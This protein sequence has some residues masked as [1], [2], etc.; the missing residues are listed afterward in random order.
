MGEIWKAQDEKLG[1][2]VAV[3][4]PKSGLIASDDYRRRLV[5]EARL[6]ASINS[7]YIASVYDADE[8]DGTLFLVMEMVDGRSM[9]E[10]ISQGPQSITL[11]LAWA[12]EM[13]EGLAVAHGA[14]LVHRDLKPEN[15]MVTANDHVK[16]LDFGLAKLLEQRDKAASE[17]LS[18]AE[19]ATLE[20][21]LP[22]TIWGTPAYMSPEQ[23]RGLP[24]DARSDVFS[25]GVLLYELTTR[26]SPFKA[27]TAL[28]S[29]TA[30]L[31]S[32]PP[33]PSTLR[34]ELPQE[35]E[36][37]ILRCLQK[38]PSHRYNDTRDLLA[39]LQGV[40]PEESA[41]VASSGSRRKHQ[42]L[43]RIVPALLLLIGMSLGLSEPIRKAVSERLFPGETKP[44]LAV[45]F[46]ENLGPSREDDYLAAGLTEDIITSLSQIQNLGVLSR[47]AVE[48]YRD[49]HVDPRDV[50]RDLGANYVLEGSIRKRGDELIVTAQLIEA[51]QGKHVWARRFE[52]PFAEI[53]AVQDSI[54]FNVAHALQIPVGT[55]EQKLVS[56]RWTRNTEAYAFFLAGRERYFNFKTPTR[57]SDARP[58]FEKALA[59]DPEYAPALAG[60]SQ[61]LSAE[62]RL[63]GVLRPGGIDRALELA[64]QA[65]TLDPRLGFAWRAEGLA[66][67]N[68]NREQEA[69]TA[70]E[71][72]I[73]LGPR[74]PENYQ[75][76]NEVLRA[77]GQWAQAE[78]VAWKG[79]GM[80][81][82][83]PVAYRALASTQL[84]Q[85]KVV[86]ATR[87][88]TLGLQR[89][90]GQPEILNVRVDVLEA[91]GE[92]DKA[93]EQLRDILRQHPDYYGATVNLGRSLRE[94]NR[95]ESD[96]VLGAILERWPN[97]P[98]AVDWVGSQWLSRGNLT[99]AKELFERTTRLDPYYINAWRN[100]ATCALRER[101]INDAESIYRQC[102]DRWP[103]EV[104]AWSMAASFYEGQKR[105]EEAEKAFR[106]RVAL[107]P[108]QA[109]VMVDLARYYARRG[110]HD[111]AEECGRTAVRLDS[112]SAKAHNHLGWE[113]LHRQS[114]AQAQSSF[115]TALRLEPMS[116]ESF[117]GLC[118]VYP[119]TE[120]KEKF[121][122]IAQ[123]W[124]ER[125]PVSADAWHALGRSRTLTGQFALSATAYERALELDPKRSNSLNNLA[126]VYGRMGLEDKELELFRRSVAADSTNP[127]PWLNLAATA[128][129]NGKEEEAW[130]SALRAAEL[131]VHALPALNGSSLRANALSF[132][133]RLA[134]KRGDSS[135]AKHYAELARQ[136]I[137]RHLR[138]YPKTPAA[139]SQAILIYAQCGDRRKVQKLSKELNVGDDPEALY[140]LACAHALIGDS[141]EALRLLKLSVLAGFTD[142][143]HMAKD[144]D[145]AGL[146][147]DPAFQ[148]ILKS[149][150]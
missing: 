112:T 129:E 13:A 17:A 143:V 56:Q 79:I 1:R 147:S 144:E 89:R 99:R 77:L 111:V 101:R 100:L 68:S 26:V 25:F 18:Q 123:L 19:T 134:Q 80:D 65:R 67:H 90:P 12:R 34:P 133:G 57:M 73:R 45:L 33:S 30:I 85:G 51:K 128:S 8:S 29:L 55:E 114:Y 84:A 140:D 27:S 82:Y 35:L 48:R 135:Q 76:L 121:L 148:Q 132:L 69:K 139:L 110:R 36:R 70:L 94:S 20:L 53:L 149:I 103:D 37:I 93:L 41:R 109:E 97:V 64:H 72:A 105:F 5:R 136:E 66:Y 6:A 4:I 31:H 71:E 9:R 146:N 22:G 102:L 47:S 44:L 39:A 16:I 2:T 107:Q 60:L 23:A 63:E 113:A 115:E 83:W 81:P 104:E 126:T 91:Q 40:R 14:G 28:D 95:A 108:G 52:G 98:R 116:T 49:K 78:S 88:A 117:K 32:E 74:V 50:G 42:A 127:F 141:V 43:T 118:L 61:T 21:T 46:L 106:K 96:S 58:W 7:P 125:F 150:P 24:V 137:E 75:L 142:K 38:D 54:A 122:E 120:N 130:T 86:D 15:V 131:S 124:V 145:L 59:L 92:Q 3:K 62:R 87:T 138:K 10:L 11:L 119:Q